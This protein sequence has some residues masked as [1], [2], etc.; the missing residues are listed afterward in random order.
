MDFISLFPTLGLFVLFLYAVAVL[1]HLLFIKKTKLFVSLISVYIA[2]ALLVIVPM[3]SPIVSDW[4]S[5]HPYIRAGAFAGVC[6]LL[7]IILSFSNLNWFSERTAPTKFS[8]SL[9]YRLAIVGLFFTTILFFFP[10][11]IKIQLGNII[12]WLFMNIIAM[13]VWFII[14][15]FL[16]FAYRFKTRRGWVE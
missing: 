12:Q 10:D 11:S 6:I 3:F 13:F 8:T 1:L 16:A 2:F 5:I 14:P 15:F 7:F 9:V 4:L